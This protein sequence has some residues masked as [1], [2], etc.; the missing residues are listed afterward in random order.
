MKATVLTIG[1]ELLIGQVVDTNAAWLSEQLNLLGIE[2]RAAI[3]VGDR[4]EA[5]GWA[6]EEALDASDLVVATGG[7]GPTADDVTRD[8]VAT[9]FGVKQQLD[10]MVLEWVRRRYGRRLS[11]QSASVA[12]V[13]AGF[14]PLFNAAGA[15][16]GLWRVH[17]HDRILVLTPGVPHEMK[18]IFTEKIA[19]RLRRLALGQV[20]LHR[21]L[22]TVGVGETS[23]QERIGDLSAF[24]GPRLRLAWLPSPGQVRLRMT[25]V[26]DGASKCID[27]LE[28]HILARIPD[29]V[30]GYD[31]DTLEAAL[32]RMLSER[33][34]TIAAAESCTGGLLLHRLT[35]TP[36]ASAYVA[37]GVVAYADAVKRSV[38]GVAADALLTHG[39][40]S[41]EVA[42]QMA[43]GVRA[44]LGASIGVSITGIAGPGGGSE[45]K[46]V[47]AVWVGYADGAHQRARRFL[48][49]RD[50]VRNKIWSVVAALDLV[51]GMLLAPSKK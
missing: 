21:T 26:G 27:A 35:N 16:P 46:P 19:P 44:S 7:L 49:G 12:I 25:A 51:R 40:V 18:A 20:I 10:P 28:Q 11:P 8:A 31:N 2:V 38:L 5:I 30:Y 39:A 13:P 15:A 4:V 22:R 24:L 14:T 45:D 3:T 34:L 48:F 23:L 42:L 32:G 29:C 41:Q 36:G 43:A 47:G 6:L 50:R 1:D 33:S 17:D 37:G 9:L